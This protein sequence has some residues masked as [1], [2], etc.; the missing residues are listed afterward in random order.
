MLRKPGFLCPGVG[1]GFL[2]CL[3]VAGCRHS[4]QDAAA[5]AEA[6]EPALCFYV[7]PDGSDANP[8]TRVRPFAS[9]ER[10][11]DA[12][13]AARIAG[14]L[15]AGG[16]AVIVRGGCFALSQ[17]FELSAEDGGTA[18]APVVYRAETGERPLLSGARRVTGFEPHAGKVLQAPLTL[19]L[20]AGARLSQLFFC[21]TRQPLA[22][23]PNAD[24]ANPHGGGF[25]Y[26]A[27]DPVRKSAT[28]PNETRRVV[29]CKPGDWR[30]WAR[31][32][33]GEVILFPRYNWRSGRVPIR[34]V[35]A[36]RRQ[37][38]LTRDIV[39]Q[40]SQ[41]IRPGD[42]YYVRGLFEELD[43]PGEWYHDAAAN[44][45]YFWP[46]GPLD[47]AEIRVPVIGDLIRI[48]PGAAWIT[49]RGFEIAE[50]DGYG[51][52]VTAATNC[53]I[54]G[55]RIHGIGGYAAVRIEEGK[56]CAV[57]GNDVWDTCG[58]GIV[59]AGGDPET[60]APAGHVVDNNYIHHV[61]AL[62]GHAAGV[63]MRGVGLRVSHN[64]IHD[65]TR[66]GIYGGGN[67]C[68]VEYNHIRHTN[69]ETEDTG[70]YYNGG[71]WHIRGQV[72]RHNFIH[73]VMGYGRHAD[74]TW[75]WPHSSCCIYLDD[76]HSG[77]RVY[78]NI[79]A[80]SALG[81]VFVHAGR[82]N[83][84]ENNILVEHGLR[85]VTFS[86]HDPS[87]DVVTRHLQTFARFRGLP[88]YAKIPEIGKMELETAWRMSGN[89]FER[90]IIAYRDPASALYRLRRN[91]FP[92]ENVFD[93]NLIWHGGHTPRTGWL[94]AA[95]VRGPNL[96]TNPGFEAAGT[97]GAPQGWEVSGLM[98]FGGGAALTSGTRAAGA[99]AVC[100]TA[101]APTG[102]IQRTRGWVT[103]SS[104]PVPV[105][106]GAAYQ[107]RIQTRALRRDTPV[108]LMAET[109][110]ARGTNRS[111]HV[112]EKHVPAGP[113]WACHTFCFRLPGAGEPGYDPALK[114]LCLRV[115]AFNGKGPVWLDGAELREAELMD[116]WSGWQAAGFDTRSILADPLFVDPDRDDYRLRPESPAFKLGFKPIPVERIG[117]YQDRLRATWP[118]TEAPGVREQ[119]LPGRH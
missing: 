43:A 113:E 11:R 118:V 26:V 110:R 39:S 1:A 51:V 70:G 103:L 7:A 112:H 77:T 101:L 63:V 20:P 68:L 102:G 86:G 4:P 98:P 25:A 53:L 15:P 36:A 79:L 65:T 46:P 107:C 104:A 84:I 8:G 18:E 9:L 31:P 78:G 100:L 90:N 22:R 88:A 42:R 111:W 19:P 105:R 32:Q 94:Q 57:I 99:R 16:A 97:N 41:T 96:L 28:L 12:I 55:N 73:D 85:Q 87:S 117:L 80:R 59:I 67:D 74:G 29:T 5:V 75:G 49:L 114:T 92:Q 47:G 50:C 72:I 81:G 82:D 61:G 48:N 24:P 35:D 62:N 71:N 44:R 76:D 17:T 21:G 37:I 69:L 115:T 14:G 52:T 93:R 38:T 91:D 54:A 60:L 6:P 66:S 95:S 116:E 109:D 83:R 119:G 33:E 58:Q 56:A 45:L 27:G 40:A 2:A 106:A 34:S 23:Y 89:R 108:R 13:R 10:A 30:S 3:M 64:L